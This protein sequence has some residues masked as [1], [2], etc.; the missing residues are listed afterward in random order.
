MLNVLEF[1][2]LLSVSNSLIGV[3]YCYTRDGKIN[4]ESMPPLDI[5]VLDYDLVGGC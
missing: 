1:N 2:R 3:P 5:M 4:A